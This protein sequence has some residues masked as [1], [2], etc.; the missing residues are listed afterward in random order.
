MIGVCISSNV[1][2]SPPP[3]PAQIQAGYDNTSRDGTCIR[4]PDRR[5]QWMMLKSQG[6][7]IIELTTAGRLVVTRY[8][9]NYF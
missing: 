7:A 9:G 5:V 2:V 6:P 8:I 1:V 4:M 3:P